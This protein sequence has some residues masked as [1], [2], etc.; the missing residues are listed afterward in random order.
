MY[1]CTVSV[2]WIRSLFLWDRGNRDKTVLM[3]ESSHA[4]LGHVEYK[5]G[6]FSGDIEGHSNSHV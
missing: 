3:S 6:T 5:T 2:Q 4:P 1:I